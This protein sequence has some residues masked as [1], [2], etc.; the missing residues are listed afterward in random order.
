MR[1][2]TFLILGTQKSGTKSAIYHLNQHPD[3]NI[4]DH[5]T[6]KFI[7]DQ[8]TDEEYEKLFDNNKK[9]TGEKTPEYMLLKESIDKIYNY[10]PN[11]KL[12]IF[13]RNPIYRAHSQYKM[14]KLRNER[15]KVPFKLS[16]KQFLKKNMNDKKIKPPDNISKY[17]CYQRGNYFEQ[18]KYIYSKFDHNLIKIIISEKVIKNPLRQYNKIFSFL[19]L[20]KLTKDEFKYKRHIHS[21]KNKKLLDIDNYIYTRNLYLN[22]IKKLYELL[23]SPIN[24]WEKDFKNRVV[25]H[26]KK[27]QNKNKNKKK[28]NINPKK[29]I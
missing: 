12:I 13:L 26:N 29:Y 23:G 21:A 24:I 27:V 1:S 16:Y 14:I 22:S 18:L 25:N 11:I 20:K 8:I 9:Q 10:N 3:I 5:E 15:N 4:L 17:Y 28:L 6:K 7:T 2:P 19:N